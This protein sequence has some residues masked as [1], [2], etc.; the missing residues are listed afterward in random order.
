MTSSRLAIFLP[1][2]VSTSANYSACT[3]VV[4]DLKDA[5]FALLI[6]VGIERVSR[7]VASP[8]YVSIGSPAF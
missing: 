1:A 5:L 7:R 8:L 6:Q 3:F 4:V 2:P